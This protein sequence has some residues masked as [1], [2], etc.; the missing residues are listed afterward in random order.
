MTARSLLRRV[1]SVDLSSTPRRMVVAGAVGVGAGLGAVALIRSIE[2]VATLVGTTGELPGDARLWVFVVLPAGLWVA[3]WLTARLGPEAAG[4][5]VPQV[6]AAMVA[7]GGRIPLAIAPLKTVVTAITLGVGGSAGREGPIAQ[8]GASFGASLSRWLGLNES[9][10]R[11]LIA[12]G[13]AAG[14]SATFNAPIA[15]MLFALEVVLGSFAATHLSP[16][17]V[18]SVLGAVVSRG[19]LG[20]ELTFEVPAYPLLNPWDLILFGGL[21]LAAAVIGYVFL[22]QLGFWEEKPRRMVPWLR[23]LSLGLLI[24]VIGF[25]RPEILGT[26]QDLIGEFLRSETGLAWWTLGI[27]AVLKAVAT[28]ATFGARGSG[29]IFMPSLFIGAALGL[30]MATLVAPYWGPSD[31]QPGA[32]ALVGMAAAFAAVA[33]APLTA[34]LIVFE[35]TGDYGLVLPLMLATLIATLV[36]QRLHRESAYSM[37]LIRLGIPVRP[38]D[39]SDLLHQVR[40]GEVIRD[41]A[42]SI[43]PGLSLAEAQGMFDRN[44]LHGAPV[45]ENGRLVGVLSISDIIASGGPSD[46]AVVR[47]AMTPDP[48][49]VDTEVP[50]SLAMQKMASLGVGRLPVVSNEDPRKLVGVFGREDAVRAYHTAVSASA[51]RALVRQEAKVH[52]SLTTDFFDIEVRLGSRVAN[53][54]I[55]EVPWPEGCLIVAVR[56]GTQIHVAGG[57]LVLLEGD[58][59]TGF[60]SP[61][62]RARLAER[63]AE[64][65]ES[66]E[67]LT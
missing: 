27:L 6:I 15:G 35:A 40:I 47:D 46:Q 39:D 61:E 38:I 23:P 19:L 1:A 55:R 10:T 5:G 25:I 28:G 37:V 3:W 52:T 16:V 43:G 30:G 33:R 24:A 53:R 14:I 9:D 56:R 4:H 31:L 17:V 29:G 12:A 44:R 41:T 60:G 36:A 7:R 50:V 20:P 49:T 21:G 51:H 63:I 67:P 32:F 58:T 57:E 62:A 26:G 42:V 54:A 13:V 48:A 22:Q 11:G 64:P 59:I 45:V 34:I 8:I 18:A 2:L 65:A 66:Q